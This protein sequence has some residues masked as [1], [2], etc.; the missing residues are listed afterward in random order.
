MLELTIEETAVRIGAHFTVSFQRTLR[1][2]DD[3]KD[4]PLPPS[5]GAFP[6]RRVEDFADRVPDDWR[7]RGGVFIPMYQREALWLN[8]LGDRWH[9]AAAKIG[10]G[11]V[12]ALT[13]KGWDRAL[14]A[15]PQDYLV[16]P[17]QPWLD[18]I[19]AGGG[20]VRQFVAMPLGEGYTVE[21]QITGEEV[22]GG[23]Q[24]VVFDA[25]AGRF[26]DEQPETTFRSR[27]AAEVGGGK[28]MMAMA[29]AP[30]G[31]SM[32]LAAGGK[33]TQAIYPDPHG[34]ATWDQGNSGELV[35]HIVNS[36]LYREITGEAPPPSPIDA[37]SYTQHG[38]PW[39][40]LY[41]EAKGKIAPSDTLA[42]VKS[43]R[44]IDQERDL[45]SQQDDDTVV[46]PEGQIRKIEPGR[47]KRIDL[48]RDDE[49]GR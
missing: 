7:E 16:C 19:N 9:P 37:R 1:L 44:E 29:A 2:P 21:G 30:A 8:F 28:L 49:G 33:M 46:V 24:I 35:V 45:P 32:G 42:K 18:G 25:K 15:D 31:A 14:H 6:I 17:H 39:Y 11:R 10:V 38:Y 47:K 4:Y 26:P 13:G 23:L 34:L 22:F 12:N 36:A 27:M 41:D 5:L 40:A 20:T 43:V 3:G 48:A